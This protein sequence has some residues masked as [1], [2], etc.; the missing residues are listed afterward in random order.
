MSLRKKTVG[1]VKWTSV[2]A[3]FSAVVQLLQIAVLTR[4]LDKGDFGLMAMAVFVIGISGVFI[5]MGVSNAIIYKQ[6]VNKYQLSTL[7]WLNVLL[8]VLIYL[9]VFIFSPLIASF[10]DSP[11]LKGVINWTSVSFLILPWGQQFGALLK[12]DFRFKSLAIRDIAAKGISFIVAVVLAY[13][14]FGVYALVYANLASAFISALLLV[15]IGMKDYRPKLVF[16]LRSIKDKGFFSFGLFQMGEKLIQYFNKNFDTLIIGKILGM[17]ALGLYEIAKNLA[18]RPYLIINP[19]ITKV[20]FPAFAKVQHDLSRL[21]RA[22][23]KVINV[24]SN[25]NAPLHIAMIMLADPLIQVVF[26]EEWKDAVPIFQWLTIGALCSSIGN[27]VGALQL[28][29]GRADWGFYWNLGRFFIVPLTIWIG[30]QFSIVGV[31][32]ALAIFRI[33]T[34][35]YFSWR[36]FIKKLTSATYFEYLNSF[37]KHVVLAIAAGLPVLIY[38]WMDFS[39]SIYINLLISGML[40]GLSILILSYKFNKENILEV[41]ETLNF[42][43]L[44][45]LKPYFVKGKYLK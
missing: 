20:A 40:Y 21:K 29:T 15:Y 32:V 4:F 26:G 19:I 12:K 37:V 2:S 9:I 5:D 36:L 18:F 11:E 6:R 25:I 39:V 1:G 7:F 17:E 35:S 41:I 31:A 24:L 38:F 10:Y 42:S 33:S 34:T 30:A 16:S 8:G 13:L 3:I 14:G 27:P 43:S 45:K 44:N 28:A 22:Y 23:L